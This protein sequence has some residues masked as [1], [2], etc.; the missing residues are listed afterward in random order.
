MTL[1]KEGILKPFN[2]AE[3]ATESMIV[4]LPDE[5]PTEAPGKITSKES[6]ARA[7]IKCLLQTLSS[8]QEEPRENTTI[9]GIYGAI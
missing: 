8:G 9:T 4:V 2:Q 7:A 3:S 1:E 5:K 6:T